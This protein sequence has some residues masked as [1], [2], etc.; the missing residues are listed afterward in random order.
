MKIVLVSTK[1][2]AHAMNFAYCM[3]L[4]GCNFSHIPLPLATIAALTPD[5]VEVTIIDENV[6]AIPDVLDADIIGFT[7]ILCQKERTFELA[8]RFRA[9]G[10]L[11]AVGGALVDDQPE[12][13]RDAMDV[14]FKGEAE[15]TW[16]RFIEEYRESRHAD[17]YHQQEWVDVKDSPI[18]RFDLIKT[19]RYSA[20]CIQITRGCPYRCEY[21]DVPTKNGGFPR[22]K[23]IENALQEIR[24]LSE[25]GYDSIFVV[26]DH[27]AGN[28]KFAKDLL[29]AIA[30]LLPSLPTKMYFYTQVS[31]NVAKDEELLQ[32]FHDASFRRLFIGI[33]TSDSEQLLNINK[34]HNIEQDILTSI[35]RIQSYGITVWAGILFGLDGDSEEKYNNQ[36][37]FI[38]KSGI[39]P[40]Q[41]G[42]LQAMPETPLYDRV[43][44][45]GRLVELPQ[46]MGSS[47][48]G[49]NKKVPAS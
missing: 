5:D 17:Y 41:I 22:S 28:R 11:V 31:L 20:G 21:C 42:L 14:V 6:E 13:C 40:V 24:L 34:K 3:D 49:D 2:E 8:K 25:I 26:D 33:E 47:G 10:K 45:E 27:F 35:R 18:P 39:T 32:L 16:P 48:L 15:Y 44:E 29:R 38:M 4:V 37:D 23:A 12:E 9:E 43:I 30:E 1:I 19:E 46:I 7:A 36:Y